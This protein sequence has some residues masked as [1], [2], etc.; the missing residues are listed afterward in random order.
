MKAAPHAPPPSGIAEFYVTRTSP[1]GEIRIFLREKSGCP[2]SE[3]VIKNDSLKS[4]VRQIHP[5]VSQTPILP[6]LEPRKRRFLRV[7]NKY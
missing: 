4:G 5:S 2:P 7:G 3:A 6:P 1:N